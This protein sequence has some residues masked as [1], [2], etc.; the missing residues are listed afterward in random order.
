MNKAK[1]GGDKIKR[2]AL[3]ASRASTHTRKF[4][5]NQPSFFLASQASFKGSFFDRETGQ[6]NN[7][8]LNF[9]T[10]FHYSKP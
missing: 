6:N 5:A 2:D 7:F 10:N 3:R 9:Y 1:G 4:L 8:S